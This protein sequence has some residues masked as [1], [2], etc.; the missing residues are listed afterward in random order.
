MTGQPAPALVWCPFPDPDAALAVIDALLQEG[1][2]ACGNVLPGMRSRFIWN[3]EVSSAN[4]AGVLL[5]TNADCLSRVV[6][7]V[8]ELHPY[9]EPA[10]LGWL[11]DA[12]A[13]GT[14][15]WLAQ[16]GR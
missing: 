12:A 2:I 6:A 15:E 16:L 8:A 14:L 1:L 3:G 7:R 10:V 5:K 9:E 4:E 11:A 13:P